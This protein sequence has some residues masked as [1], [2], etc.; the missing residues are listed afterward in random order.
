MVL[1]GLALAAAACGPPRPLTPQASYD[2]FCARCHGD[3]GTGDPRTVGLNPKLDLI[4]SDMIKSRDREAIRQ[5]IVQ[6]EGSM[7]GF[8]EKLEPHEVDELVAYTLE[9]F[10][11][12]ASSGAAGSELAPALGSNPKP[13]PGGA[14]DPGP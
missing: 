12:Q 4:A 13:E 2:Y 10:G 1:L 3:D 9:R 8:Q 7:P 14:S 11:P 5:R 6:G